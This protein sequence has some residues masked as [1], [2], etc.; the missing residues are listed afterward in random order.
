MVICLTRC[1]QRL[2]AYIWRALFSLW[3]VITYCLR[4]TI[5][6][7]Q[8]VFLGLLCV[9]VDHV[10]SLHFVQKNDYLRAIVDNFGHGLIAAISWLV[11]SGIRK[12]G[13]IQGVCCAMMSSGLD[14]DHFV[15][16]KSLK[17]KVRTIDIFMYLL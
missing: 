16:A 1:L 11:V 12:E 5:F 15:M 2:S 6:I 3:D 10:V 17:I 8:Y 7:L 14:I 9:G 13:I 4:K